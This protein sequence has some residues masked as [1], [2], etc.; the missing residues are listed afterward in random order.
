MFVIGTG[1]AGLAAIGAANSLGAVV[2][3]TDVRPETA[4]QVTSMGATFLHVDQ[5]D[6]RI[7]SDG[8]AKEVSADYAARAAELYASQAREVDIIITTAGP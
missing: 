7:S 4:E 8:Y 5:A 2:R 6:Q 1:V 3:A